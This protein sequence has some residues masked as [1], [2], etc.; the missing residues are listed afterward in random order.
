MWFFCPSNTQLQTAAQS[1]C[2]EVIASAKDRE[3][4]RK[5]FRPTR[6]NFSVVDLLFRRLWCDTGGLRRRW[7]ASGRCSPQSERPSCAIR[8][9]RFPSYRRVLPKPAPPSGK[10]RNVSISAAN[11]LFRLSIIAVTWKNR[12]W[13][14]LWLSPSR[15]L[16][17]YILW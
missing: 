6:S 8:K 3:R 10:Q 15:M 13:L 11:L 2:E 17:L 7:A 5:P 4:T 16:V 14:I 12:H 9:H 1:Y